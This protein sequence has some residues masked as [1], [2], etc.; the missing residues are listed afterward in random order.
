MGECMEY[1]EVKQNLS[2]CPDLAGLDEA[3]TSALLWRGEEQTLADGEVVYVEGEKL[4][5]TFC[6]LLSGDLLVEKAGKEIGIISEQQVFGEM[7][8]FTNQRA[9]TAT[10]RAG[11]PHA[12]VLKIR[13]TPAEL[14]RPPLGSLRKCLERKTWDRFVN[15]SQGMS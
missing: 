13:L 15:T 4:D 9:R 3:S 12:V 11:F 6:V 1:N 2:R 5:H 10:V 8:Y 7:A 14:G